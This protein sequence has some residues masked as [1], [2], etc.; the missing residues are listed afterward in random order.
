MKKEELKLRGILTLETIKHGKVIE[1]EIIKNTITNVGKADAI[2]RIGG[3]GSIVAYQWL[4]IGNSSTSVVSSDTKLTGEFTAPTSLD[5]AAGTGSQVTENVTND[6]LQLVKTFINNSSSVATVKEAG[7][8]NTS[9]Q[10]TANA[11][12]RQTFGGKT[13]EEDVELRVT[14]KVTIA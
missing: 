2:G 13:L 7:I 10:D 14:Y 1:K 9:T 12:G 8:F 6:T 11:L 3:L 4:A 5:R